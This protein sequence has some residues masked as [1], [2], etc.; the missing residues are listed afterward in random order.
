[1]DSVRKNAILRLVVEGS[2]PLSIASIS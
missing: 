2:L 1:L